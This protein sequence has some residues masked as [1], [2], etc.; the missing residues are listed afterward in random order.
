MDTVAL[1][2]SSSGLLIATYVVLG[3]GVG[4]FL[5]VVIHRMPRMMEAR[6]RAECVELNGGESDKAPP[7]ERY[8]L[9]RPRSSCPA[10]GH[11]IRAVDNIPVLSFLVLRGKC[12][13]C[14][15]PISPRYPLIEV[16]TGVLS[17]YA[18]WRL[19]FTFAALGAL[20]FI[21]SMIVLAFID[22]DTFYLPDDI[23]LPLIWAGLLFNLSGGFV[24][25]PSAVAGAAA[26]Y[27]TLWVVFWMFKLATGKEGMGYGDFK[28]LAAIGAWL[29]WKILPLVILLSSFVGA[30]AGVA[31]IALARRGRNVPIPFGPY[32]A[33]AGL[34][35][36]FHGEALTRR[37]LEVFF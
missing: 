15:A 21:W 10:C 26:G 37:Y 18:A 31:L 14:R 8:N 19:G 3:L 24:D 20:I 9:I 17:G 7:P 22:M 32:L 11:R 4:S 16:L 34:I 1:L 29:G 6:W 27:L 23:T 28:L 25:L 33:A 2:Q 13:A 35:A 12:K 30:I 5:N 36:L